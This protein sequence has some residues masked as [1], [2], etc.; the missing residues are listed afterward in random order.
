VKLTRIFAPA[1]VTALALAAL[2]CMSAEERIA[3]HLERARVFEESGQN[4]KALIE[5]QNALKL[6]PQ[7]AET[8]YVNGELLRKMERWNDALF[9]YEEAHRL[10]PKRDDAQLGI[11]F[12]LRF[13]DTDRAE[14]LVEE[15]VARSPQDPKAHLLRSDLY[16]VR[17]DVNGALA[18]ALT[19]LELDPQSARVALQ[20]AMARKAFIAQAEKTG[21]PIEP[22]LFDETDAALAH[23]IELAKVDQDLTWLV[24]G[25]TERA[26]LMTAR[27]GHGPEVVRMYQEAY[28]L[29]KDAPFH[30]STLLRSIERSARRSKDRAFL[31]WAL[32]RGVE[33]RPANH[34]AWVELANRTSQAGGD[35]HAVMERMLKER[36]DDARSH[37]TYAEYLSNNGRT[38]DGIAHLQ[39]VLPDS[40]A[41]DS[42]MSALMTLQLLDR[43]PDDAAKTLAR[44]RQEHP[45]SAQT[46]FA[47]ATLANY[48]GRNADAIAALERWTAREESPNGF[49]MLADARVRAG[50]PRDALD[51]IDRA[52]ALTGRPRADYQRLRGRI[53]VMLGDFEAA[54]Q[55][56]SRSRRQG[57]PI[58]LEFMPD[59]ARAL[60]MR[61]N[62]NAARQA[63]ERAL[64]LET[65]PPAALLL[66]GREEAQRDPKASLAALERGASLYPQQPIFVDMLVAHDLRAGDPESALARVRA[67]VERMPDLP[68]VHMTLARTLVIANQRDEAVTQ[69]ELVQQRWPGQPGVAEL[70]LE[71]MTQAGRGDQAF[72]A[73]TKQREAGTLPPNGRVLL[74]RLHVRRGE[75]TQA[76]ELLRSAIADSPELPAAQNDLAYLLA[77]RGEDYEAATELAQEARANRPDSPEIA[78]TLGYVYLKRELAEAALVQFDAAL[79]LAEPGSAGWATAQYHRGLALRQLGRPADAVSALEQALAS[80]AEFN[81]AQ[82]AHKAL[83]D[84]GNGAAKEGS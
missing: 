47:E 3:N 59:L 75:D 50:N 22:Q 12:L 45:E 62:P 61:G 74:A 30:A 34:D 24:R 76:L 28:E 13:S 18:S 77:R 26:E 46:F 70:Y 72:E 48:E 81:E 23:A 29:V 63:L 82:E 64:A 33:L 25:V 54:L 14:K 27:N 9:Y 78:D 40:K 83:A 2:G 51:A 36:P 19:A 31:V 10:D 49:A 4:D 71:V 79:E 8:N 66:F 39:K 20:V 53:L 52:I 38:A 60:Y 67:A 80:G 68:R 58:P 37:I 1:L 17:A 5:L 6:D 21:K 44:L 35:G 11:A 56:F 43:K 7:R 15:V 32:E 42:T 69:A 73:L 65:P 84:L 16:L 55:A 57:G 41:Q